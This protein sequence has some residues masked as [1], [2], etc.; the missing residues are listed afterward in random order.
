MLDLNGDG[1]PEVVI[2]EDNVF[3][4]Y[5]SEGR[6]GYAA[7]RKTTKPFDEEAGP[8]IVFADAKQTIY[9]ADMSGDGMTD[10][11]R[12]RNGEVCYWPNMGYGKFG[13][14]VALDNAPVFDH[15]DAFNP[16]YLRLADIDGSGTSDIIYLGKNKFTCW[17]NLSGNRFSSTPFEIDPFPEVNTQSKI[18]VTDLLGNGVACIVW[19]SPLAKD[20]N[21]PLK[22]IDLMN[23]KKPHIMVS[24]KNNLGKE[25]LLEYT[26]STKFYIED[27]LNGKPWVTKLHFP[28]HCVSKT[29]TEDKISGYKFVS[30]Y[31]YHHGYYDHPER[32]FRGFGMV[33]QTD[34]ETFE[35]WVK[36]GAINIYRCH[37]APGTSGFKNMEPHRSLFT[38]R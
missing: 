33:E 32:E 37:F 15:P 19:S 4:W 28:V 24:Y 1:K 9:L 13:E 10:I 12:I 11:L 29:T 18:T 5:A 8:H 27:K 21:A 6:D 34:A 16:A 36:S 17:K 22:Y 14:K 38:K 20:S 30:E 3:T 25:V 7:A 26:P 35:H 31:K 2:S 23:S